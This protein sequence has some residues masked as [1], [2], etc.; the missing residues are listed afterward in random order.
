VEDAFFGNRLFA[1][2]SVDLAMA[3]SLESETYNPLAREIV[4]FVGPIT[5]GGSNVDCEA[6]LGVIR[7]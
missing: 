1:W 5:K 3:E 4:A 2:I 7:D 6:N